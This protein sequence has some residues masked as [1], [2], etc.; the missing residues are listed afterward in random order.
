[1]AYND[2]MTRFG[3]IVTQ[4]FQQVKANHLI[5]HEGVTLEE[6]HRR[7]SVNDEILGTSLTKN[8]QKKKTMTNASP[9]PY[10]HKNENRDFMK[11]MN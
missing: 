8:F 9:Q 11:L 5:D 3:E 10:V 6:S 4:K 2:R 1:M 7:S